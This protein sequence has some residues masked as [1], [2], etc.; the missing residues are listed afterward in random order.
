MFYKG[1]GCES[2]ANSGS[3]GRVGVYEVMMMSERLRDIILNGGSTD[4]IRRQPLKKACCH[5][6][7]QRCAKL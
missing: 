2:C 6:A 3:R 7:N 5:C 1:K 4:D